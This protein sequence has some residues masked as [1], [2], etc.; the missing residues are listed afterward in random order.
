M[1][2]LLKL[3]KKFILLLS[4]VFLLIFFFFFQYLIQ[5]KNKNVNKSENISI[6]PDGSSYDIKNPKFTINNKND[7]IVVSAKEGNFINNNEILLR[8]NVNFKSKNFSLKTTE[9]IYDKDNQTAQSKSASVFFA[10]KTKIKSSGFE[11]RDSG[12]LIILKGKTNI[13]IS[14]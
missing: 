12:N 4:I 1:N 14:K 9:V 5:S 13:I 3:D 10:K 8:N 7:N 11:L 2:N 6:I